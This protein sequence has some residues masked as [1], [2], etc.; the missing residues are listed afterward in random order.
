MAGRFPAV[1]IRQTLGR[2]YRRHV[3]LRLQEIRP[4]R[5][6]AQYN[7]DMLVSRLL[8]SVDTVIDVGAND[9]V[10]D[11]NSF[12]FVVRGASALLFEPIPENFRALQ[13]FTW[14]APNVVAVNEGISD[15]EGELE[16]AVQGVLS[17]ATDTEDPAHSES[18]RSVL[19]HDPRHLRVVVR[20][21]SYWVERLPKFAEPDL[22]SID[23]EGHELKVLEG[24]DFT[25]CRPR[26]LVLETHGPSASG[27]WLHRDYQALTAL[28]RARGYVYGLSTLGNSIWIRAGDRASARVGG[29]VANDANV[30][31]ETP[32]ALG[33]IIQRRYS[34]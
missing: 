24:I 18:C 11:S 2:W 9:G 29:I 34:L 30:F 13:D 5:S 22:V 31:T 17:F 15:R 14:S 3:F 7:E 21:M 32:D 26:A 28:L 1:T 27:Y 10:S 12:F 16:F 23:V 33:A 8:D 6:Y 4:R 25:T 20:P 19:P